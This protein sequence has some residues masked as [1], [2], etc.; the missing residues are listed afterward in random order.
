MFVITGLLT[1]KENWERTWNL[2]PFVNVPDKEE[3]GRET[4]R[5]EGQWEGERN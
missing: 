5:R 1:P 4:N 2:A 3:T